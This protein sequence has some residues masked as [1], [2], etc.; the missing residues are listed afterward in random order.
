[1]ADITKKIDKSIPSTGR[2]VYWDCSENADDG[3]P[4]AQGDVFR[5][6]T[7]LGR[8]GKVTITTTSATSDLTVRPNSRTTIYPRQYEG[9]EQNLRFGEAFQNMA[10]GVEV[11]HPGQAALPA[12]GVSTTFGFTCSDIEIVNW[13]YGTFTV[14][15]V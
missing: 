2:Y 4:I 11:T 3:T 8:P 14:L 9:P 5:I 7:S 12:S 10:L 15:V 6:T 1:M 13:T